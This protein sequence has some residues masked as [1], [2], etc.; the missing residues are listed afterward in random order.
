MMKKL[1]PALI[2]GMG[3]SAGAFASDGTITING[4]LTAQTCTI[5]GNNQGSD[6]TVTLPTI[7][8]ATLATP[9]SIAGAVP[10][11]IVLSACTPATGNVATYFEYGANT[12]A[13][14][15]L[16]NAT[17]SATSVEVQLLNGDMSPIDVS[18][19]STTLQ[20]SAV[21]F[22]ASGGATLPYVARYTS[23]LGN[24]TAGDVKTTVTYSMTYQ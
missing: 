16:K 20:N 14:G 5:V 1:I 3:L 19:G 21:K 4:A 9:N 10:F 8:T 11:S 6:F 13:D 23:P 17:G 2:I 22:L 7:S 24:A 15:N 12:L 18:K